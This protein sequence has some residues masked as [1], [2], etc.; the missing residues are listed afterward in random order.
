M[1]KRKYKFTVV[2]EVLVRADN[3]EEANRQV[4]RVL[5]F[6]REWRTITCAV[7]SVKAKGNVG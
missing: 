6:R 4:V 5:P 3:D 2:G 7:K 1:A